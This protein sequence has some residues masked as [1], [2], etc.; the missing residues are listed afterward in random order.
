MANCLEVAFKTNIT[1]PRRQSLVVKTADWQLL[2]KPWRPL[3]LLAIAETEL[4]AAD[5]E[6]S[7]SMSRR[8]PSG[9]RG[10]NRRGGRG[11]S[12]PMDS[13]PSAIEMLL[14]SEY[15]SAF[16]LAVLMVHKLLNKDEWDEQW[17]ATEKSLRE[18]CLEKGVHPVWHDLAQ[19]TALLG[20]FAAFPKAKVSKAKAGKKVKL[21]S[22]FINPFI[23]EDLITAVE[24][25]SPV[26]TDAESQVALRNIVSQLSSG[27]Q[28][29][30]AEILYRLDG[31]ASALSVLFALASGQDP[32]EPLK[33]LKAV[34][35][36]L[37]EQLNDLH[38]L[39]QGKVLDWK[40]S[41]TAKG[42]HSLAVARQLLAWENTPD[43][44]AKLS[45]KPM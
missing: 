19:R 3:L 38:M 30:P 32:T 18:I 37:A 33:R 10:R 41:R 13:L 20:Q 2:E 17:E 16:R 36:D 22:A 21:T 39:R 8:R 45:S 1:K 26:V 28:L 43:E 25:I 12:G 6:E 24:E 23:T 44:A 7:D 35:T 40:K 11:S 9:G 34:D 42:N 15:S 27:R 31:Q 14:P 5:E 29:L 4:P